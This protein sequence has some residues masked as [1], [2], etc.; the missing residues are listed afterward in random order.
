MDS[1]KYGWHYQ[2]DNKPIWLFL[3]P[4]RWWAELEFHLAGNGRLFLS[5]R[6]RRSV[7]WHAIYSISFYALVL[8]ACAHLLVNSSGGR[9]RQHASELPSS[10]IYNEVATSSREEMPA[11]PEIATAEIP[12]EPAQSMALSI[13]ANEVPVA[14]EP[15][16]GSHSGRDVA[17]IKPRAQDGAA[18]TASVGTGELEGL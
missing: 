5:A 13:E 12:S 10:A 8:L 3:A 1:N 11:R 4:G 17:K 18:D 2:K 14:A 9:P 15:P 6:R 7:I 16:T